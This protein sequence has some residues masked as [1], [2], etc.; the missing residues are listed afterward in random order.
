MTVDENKGHS[1]KIHA[2]SNDINAAFQIS[3]SQIESEKN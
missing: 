2:I 3:S 1:L